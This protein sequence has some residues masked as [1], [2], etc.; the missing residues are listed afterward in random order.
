MDRPEPQSKLVPFEPL[1][2]AVKNAPVINFRPDTAL[3]PPEEEV[4]LPVFWRVLK[5]RAWKVASC[6]AVVFFTVLIGTLKQTP[7]Y[8]AA[9]LI[10]IDKE[11]PNI[12]S[13]KEILKL[14]GNSDEYLETQY[15]LLRSRSLA[16]KVV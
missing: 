5:K 8:E 1:P 14:D 13:F 2:P 9:A 12:L 11:N 6:L 3:A 10:E 4:P 15:R 7:I 16:E